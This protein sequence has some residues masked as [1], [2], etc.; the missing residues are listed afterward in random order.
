MQPSTLPRCFRVGIFP[1]ISIKL[2]GAKRR[3]G[4]EATEEKPKVSSLLDTL[5]TTVHFE[6]CFQPF[7]EKALGVFLA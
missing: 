4:S 2:Q 3:A 1:F 5:E 7:S 6:K